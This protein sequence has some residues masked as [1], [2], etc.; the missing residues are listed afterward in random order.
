MYGERHHYGCRVYREQNQ[1]EGTEHVFAMCLTKNKMCTRVN[2]QRIC[3]CTYYSNTSPCIQ[4]YGISRTNIHGTYLC[5]TNE[6][7]KHKCFNR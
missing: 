1:D 7:T 5:S 4:Y 3:T 6:D 2:T